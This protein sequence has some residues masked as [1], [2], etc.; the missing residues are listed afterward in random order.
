MRNSSASVLASILASPRASRRVSRPSLFASVALAGVLA[1]TMS[2]SASADV[3]VNFTS[4][5]LN[6]F[7]YL[8]AAALF[9]GLSY[10]GSL[11]AVT[12]CITLDAS[13]NGVMCSEFSVYIDVPP[14]S[15]GG[16]LQVGGF[17]NFSAAQR[18][19]WLQGNSSAIGTSIHET[20]TLTSAIALDST[21]VGGPRVYLGNNNAL[22]QGTW[23]G[24]VTFHGVDGNGGDPC[25]P[26]PG[27]LAAFAIFGLGARRRR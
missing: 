12:A 11:T 16:L 27:A 23:T 19:L 2:R 9:S 14:L 8:D 22:N 15:T 6:G 13:T 26:A 3:T 4:L 1:A 21:Q 20:V 5:D 24:S 25:I 18:Y 7:E 10:T 17:N